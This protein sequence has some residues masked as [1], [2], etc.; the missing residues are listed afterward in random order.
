MIH[1]EGVQDFA[2]QRLHVLQIGLGTFGTF[3]EHITD[4]KERYQFLSWLLPAVTDSSSLL[5]AVG[6]EPLREICSRLVPMLKGLPNAALVH[7]AMGCQ[8]EDLL[9]YRMNPDA[10]R[11]RI[12]LDQCDVYDAAVLYLKNMSCVGQV[13]PYA[14]PC[15]EDI[16]KDFGVCIEI[17]KVHVTGITYGDL[18]CMLNCSGT[19]LLV[20]D[21]EGHDCQILRSMIDYCT[22]KA[23]SA[24]PTIIHFETQGI[25][26]VV[27]G[28]GSE[29]RV[30]SALE[31]LGYLLFY[32]A[33][34]TTMVRKNA[35]TCGSALAQWID[36]HRC[37]YC[38]DKGLKCLPW[39]NASKEHEYQC[40]A[41]T[42]IAAEGLWLLTFV[43]P[44]QKLPDNM[45]VK[46]VCPTGS[47]LWGISANSMLC[48]LTE[49]EWCSSQKKLSQMSVSKD[50]V[51]WA[52]DE[53]GR[54]LNC[55]LHS[56]DTW[57]VLPVNRPMRQVALARDGDLVFAISIDGSV[58]RYSCVGQHWNYVAG[59]FESLA[60]SNDGNNMW[61]V[62]ANHEVFYSSNHG[63]TWDHVHGSMK[64]IALSGDGKHLW[65][66]N[67]FGQ[68]YYRCGIRGTWIEMGWKLL[69]VAVSHDGSQVWGVD[70]NGLLWTCECPW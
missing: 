17:E 29:D 52:V 63:Q 1:I 12:E 68:V 30:I 55:K 67:M 59:C 16:R 53:D 13:H 24:W 25:C 70:K 2:G 43:G 32:R 40:K 37:Y 39:S 66:V 58:H 61:A 27:D 36:S 60:V 69:S 65:G 49:S 7:A 57:T 54:V 42:D 9:M 8:K 21:A 64:E 34:D 4:E 14:M 47:C 11:S 50:D 18:H 44:W 35:I 5:R 10:C 46:H 23:D 62:N 51:C 48:H 22:N 26:D 19:E 15:L 38:K 45:C 20:I 41:C 56:S 28:S 31:S 3:I 6:V 33:N